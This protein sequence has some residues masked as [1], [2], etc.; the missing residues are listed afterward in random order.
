M[1]KE[2]QHL[3]TQKVSK[4]LNWKHHPLST[5]DAGPE[6]NCVITC[7]LPMYAT[8]FHRSFF[9]S[10][11]GDKSSSGSFPNWM[12]RQFVHWAS[13]SAKDWAT[14]S[15]LEVNSTTWWR[16][17]TKQNARDGPLESTVIFTAKSVWSLLQP[18]RP[19]FAAFWCPR[20]LWSWWTPSP[21]RTQRE[22]SV[23]L[24]DTP[25]PCRTS[26]EP[27]QAF[28]GQ[29]SRTWGEA[30][31]WWGKERWQKHTT[32]PTSI[33]SQPS[34]FYLVHSGSWGAELLNSHLD[35]VQLNVRSVTDRC[36]S[37]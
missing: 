29:S 26:G 28:R 11:T 25:T 9:F 6:A 13:L 3:Y 14:G 37:L 1:H 21:L 30:G 36:P 16:K 35:Y 24:S 27:P 32:V 4:K 7:I 18:P 19:L 5:S 33:F 2:K 20:C 34:A 10:T 31:T 15:S 17:K 22:R 12:T 23:L 8:S